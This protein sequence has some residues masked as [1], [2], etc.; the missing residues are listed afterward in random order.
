MGQAM[1]VLVFRVIGAAAFQGTLVPGVRAAGGHPHGTVFEFNP[2]YDPYL[3]NSAGA[4]IAWQSRQ[5]RQS[6]SLG[7]H[8]SHDSHPVAAVMARGRSLELNKEI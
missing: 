8:G 2:H 7:S 1:R 6:S 3:V 4:A 5:S